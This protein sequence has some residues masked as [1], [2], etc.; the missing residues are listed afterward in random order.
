MIPDE[1]L[2]AE[3]CSIVIQFSIDFQ[4]RKLKAKSESIPLQLQLLA[5]DILWVSLVA[6]MVKKLPELQET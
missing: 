2:L 5:P 4:N 1:E 3:N 6:Q